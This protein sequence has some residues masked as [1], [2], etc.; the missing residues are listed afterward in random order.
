[1]E[2]VLELR[3]FI[4]LLDV[5]WRNG[6]LGVLLEQDSRPRLLVEVLLIVAAA[7]SRPGPLSVLEFGRRGLLEVLVEFVVRG[8]SRLLEEVPEL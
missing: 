3:R 5:R 4:G 6:L 1:M 7:E 2:Q 8:I